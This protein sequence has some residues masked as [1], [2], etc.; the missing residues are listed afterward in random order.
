MSDEPRLVVRLQTDEAGQPVIRR[1]SERNYYGVVLEVQDAPAD[2]FIARF[3]FDPSYSD[4]SRSVHRSPQG[5][6][7]LEVATD[8]DCPL[9]VRLLRP[10]EVDVILRDGVVRGLRREYGSDI[11]PPTIAQAVSDIAAH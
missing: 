3:D 11:L 6:F 10:G 2:A 7:R 1:R 5:T 8:G 4:D 9:V